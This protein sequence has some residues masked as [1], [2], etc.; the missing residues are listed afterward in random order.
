MYQLAKQLK[1]VA[2]GLLH[3]LRGQVVNIFG[4]EVKLFIKIQLLQLI[5]LLYVIRHGRQ[6]MNL[7]MKLILLKIQPLQL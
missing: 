4:L 3:L 1:Q 5:Q 7:K 6:L 2:H